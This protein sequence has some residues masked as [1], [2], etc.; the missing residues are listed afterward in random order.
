MNDVLYSGA[1]QEVWKLDVGNWSWKWA[2]C[3]AREELERAVSGVWRLVA[4]GTSC[5]AETCG[6][7][8]ARVHEI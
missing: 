8:W 6:K 3:Q 2:L 5:N 7:A 4:D 1:W